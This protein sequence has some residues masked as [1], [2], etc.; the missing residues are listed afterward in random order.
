MFNP[1]FIDINSNDPRKHMSDVIN[2]DRH[3]YTRQ[4]LITLYRANTAFVCMLRDGPSA[5]DVEKAMLDPDAEPVILQHEKATQ[6]SIK[7]QFGEAGL[8]CYLVLREKPLLI[9]STIDPN[10]YERSNFLTYTGP[11]TYLGQK[12]RYL[13]SRSTTFT[14]TSGSNTSPI[15]TINLEDFER[16]VDF[17]VLYRN[18]FFLIDGYKCTDPAECYER[19]SQGSH[20]FCYEVVPLESQYSISVT[21]H[22]LINLFYVN[23]YRFSGI[24]SLKLLWG[25]SFPDYCIS[26]IEDTL[27]NLDLGY[28][29]IVDCSLDSYVIHV[30]PVAMDYQFCIG[31]GEDHFLARDDYVFSID[32]TSE[33][34][35]DLQ[36]F[37]V[38]NKTSI[39]PSTI[40]IGLNVPFT[41]ED[42]Q[43]SL[44]VIDQRYHFME[45][46]SDDRPDGYLFRDTCDIYLTCGPDAYNF[47]NRLSV[48]DLLSRI[49]WESQ[50]S[51]IL[52]TRNYTLSRLGFAVVKA[53]DRDGFRYMYKALDSFGDPVYCQHDNPS[54]MS[55]RGHMGERVSDHQYR[56]IQTYKGLEDFLASHKVHKPHVVLDRFGRSWR[57]AACGTDSLGNLAKVY[58]RVFVSEP[59]EYQT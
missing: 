14:I 22:P 39:G 10:S 25:R 4:Q 37:E 49:V 59:L 26:R 42:V 52:P 58:A 18:Y 34:D 32:S 36:Y 12:I 24:L 35:D 38:V 40:E 17:F 29:D 11:M 7:I 45:P 6:H 23:G 15:S 21:G 16:K 43:K 33:S 55:K 2:R 28:D 41:L 30:E 54:L 13:P 46:I 56:M 51:F 27:T 5:L 48:V 31:R 20:V 50:Y 3:K 19:I 44:L 1:L 53:K 47:L 57:V 8:E 9:E